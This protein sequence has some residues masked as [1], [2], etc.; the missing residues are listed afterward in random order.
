MTLA[1]QNLRE[2]W[3]ASPMEDIWRIARPVKA[4]A[5]ASRRRLAVMS[6]KTCGRCAYAVSDRS[7]RR[8][9]AADPDADHLLAVFARAHQVR[10]RVRFLHRRV[11]RRGNRRRVRASLRAGPPRRERARI[12]DGAHRAEPDAR[13]AAPRPPPPPR[14]LRRR[15]AACPPRTCG[16]TDV[17][18]AR[19]RRP[20]AGTRTPVMISPGAS[21]VSRSRRRTGQRQRPVPV[22]PAHRH[23][24]RRRTG[25]RVPDPRRLRLSRGC[26]RASRCS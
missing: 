12:A 8:Y 1:R 14:A 26:R 4:P 9:Q 5:P 19:A 21:A 16:R 2:A 23:R 11:G 13:V 18:G 15:R 24:P 3:G 10:E 17:A 7:Q 22:G 20:A 25:A 6:S